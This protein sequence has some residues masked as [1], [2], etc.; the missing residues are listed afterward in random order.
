LENGFYP[1]SYNVRTHTFSFENPV[2]LIDQLYTAFHLEKAGVK[3][4]EF[5]EWLKAEFY[6]NGR[7]NGRY[8][9]NTKKQAVDYESASVYALTIL[10][11]LERNDRSF[12]KDVYER[13]VAMRVDDK[14][15]NHYGGYVVNG[16][17]HSFDNL[18][19]LLAERIFLYE[20]V[21]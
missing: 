2:N 1:K 9:R 18:L 14:Q 17:T 5:Y 3:T 13:M 8:D 20:T 4:D 12:A 7:L 6:Q 21:E 15:S 16:E 11:S 19:P 10:Y